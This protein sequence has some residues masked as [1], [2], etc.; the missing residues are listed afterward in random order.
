MF[1]SKGMVQLLDRLLDLEAGEGRNSGSQNCLGVPGS[2]KGLGEMGLVVEENWKRKCSR[3]DFK[4]WFCHV[5]ACALLPVHYSS[6]TGLVHHTL[7]KQSERFKA[8]FPSDLV[9]IYSI[10]VSTLWIFSVRDTV[11]SVYDK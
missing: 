8:R 10:F 9:C 3:P 1:S 6:G 4:S 5:L 11:V 2:K 7:G